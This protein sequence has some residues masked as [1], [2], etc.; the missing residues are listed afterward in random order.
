M[1]AVALKVSQMV[2]WPCWRTGTQLL[3][4]ILMSVSS[5][6]FVNKRLVSDAAPACFLAELFEDSGIDSDRD[7]LARLIAEGR[8]ADAPHRLQLLRR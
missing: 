6:D 5:E 7:Q 3:R 4:D 1:R 8:P 2:G